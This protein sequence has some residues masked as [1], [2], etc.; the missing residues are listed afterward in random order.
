VLKEPYNWVIDN[1]GSRQP[2]LELTWTL[3]F[4]GRGRQGRV[5]AKVQKMGQPATEGVASEIG[6]GRRTRST[7]QAAMPANPSMSNNGDDNDDEDD[8]YEEADSDSEESQ[9]EEEDISEFI[10]TPRR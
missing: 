10:A 4:E 2:G 6:E 5:R 3:D 7:R 1:A 9:D 8:D